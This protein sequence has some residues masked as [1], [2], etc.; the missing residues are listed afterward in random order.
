MPSQKNEEF[1]SFSKYERQKLQRLYTQCG[2]A[3]PSMRTLVKANNLPV[4]KGE[5]VFAFSDFV[6]KLF[7]ATHI[8]EGLKAFALF[9]NKIWCMNLAHVDKITENNN[10]VKYLLV[11][12][13]LFDRAVDAKR[14]KAKVSEKRFV[15]F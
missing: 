5:T 7:L 14:M 15:H 9:E 6:R 10:G 12:Q 3:Y 1:K 2:A 8:S 13:D 4:S 11:R